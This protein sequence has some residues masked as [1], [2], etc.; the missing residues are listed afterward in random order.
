[1]LY[2]AENIS[3]F[4]EGCNFKIKMPKKVRPAGDN[5]L[6]KVRA[7]K[8]NASCAQCVEVVVGVFCVYSFCAGRLFL[9]EMCDIWSVLS[10]SM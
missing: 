9:D 1:M 4:V 3:V 2:R 7:L 10:I 8:V 6:L 5:W